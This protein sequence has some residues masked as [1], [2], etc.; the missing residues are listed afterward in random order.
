[1][2]TKVK[3]FEWSKTWN[4]IG[5]LTWV[6]IERWQKGGAN[7][8]QKKMFKRITTAMHPSGDHPIAKG[9][10]EGLPKNPWNPCAKKVKFF[11]L[12]Q[13]TSGKK[14]PNS[15]RLKV[16]LCKTNHQDWEGLARAFTFKF[17]LWYLVIQSESRHYRK[18]VMWCSF[19][20]HQQNN[21][22]L[23][24]FQYL[25]ELFRLPHKTKQDMKMLNPS[26]NCAMLGIQLLM[27]L[28]KYN[29]NIDI[30]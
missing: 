20:I 9:S 3:G 19:M 11:G 26:M 10:S 1:M 17:E 27:P 25:F 6:K 12:V 18:L 28:F 7:I 23:V 4:K 8:L 16:G 13:R 14:D 29:S 5:A 22:F 30:G 21:K 15:E 24:D 2:D